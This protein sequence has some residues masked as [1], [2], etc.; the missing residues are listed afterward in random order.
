MQVLLN[1]TNEI[2]MDTLSATMEAIVATFPEQLAPY[3]VQ[4]GGQLTTSFLRLVQGL[5][6]DLGDD[7]DEAILDEQ[8]NRTMGA[9]GIMKTISTLVVS[10]DS[11]AELLGELELVVLPVLVEALGK[12][13]LDLYVYFPS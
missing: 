2:D 1:L 10:L 3:A 6:V 4:L 8:C 5:D 11:S 13:L 12:D 9:I 7:A